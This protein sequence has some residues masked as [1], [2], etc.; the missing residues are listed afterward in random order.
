MGVVAC[1]LVEGVCVALRS[2]VWGCIVAC[3]GVL[4]GDV[5]K[6]GGVWDNLMMVMME[7]IGDGDEE[8]IDDGKEVTYILNA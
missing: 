7:R 6:R 5:Y 4:E 1:F 3:F 8:M 2:W